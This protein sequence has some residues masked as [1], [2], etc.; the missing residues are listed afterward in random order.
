MRRAAGWFAAAGVLLALGVPA[1]GPAQAQPVPEEP[2]CTD[3]VSAW[4]TRSPAPLATMAVQDVW[5][6]GALGAGITVAV[7]HA[8]VDGRN[9]HLR[10]AMLPGRT[11]VPG[12]TDAS[13]QTTVVD[14]GTALASVVAGRRVDGSGVVGVAPEASVMSVRWYVADDSEDPGGSKQ[15]AG[16]ARLGEA[17]AWAG[18]NGADVVVVPNA[19]T[20]PD[21]AL[22]RAVASAQEAGA[23]VLAS[24]GDSTEGEPRWPAAYPG[25]LGVVG[26]SAD[27]A[28]VEEPVRGEQVAIAAPGNDVVAAESDR[29]DCLVLGPQDPPASEWAVGYLA[30]AA[31]AV[32]SGLPNASAEEVGYRLLAS[33]ERPRQSARTETTGWG[34]VRPYAALTLTLDPTRVGPPF[35]GEVAAPVP[36]GVRTIEAGR[37]V[38]DP[39]GPQ[40]RAVVWWGLLGVAALGLIVLLTRWN[41]L[42]EAAAGRPARE[43]P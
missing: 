14:E 23:L 38:V 6:E 21:P 25:V 20:A 3:D 28:A 22:E 34:E 11:F 42:A 5:D 24:A 12:D 16:V 10:G 8:G 15:A 1:T 27:G 18:Q 40:R 33:A 13:G 36:D 29:R 41:R 43:E 30:G 7:V 2:G 32:W 35:P 17:I 9:P 31:A 26:V 37:A 39:A 19:V 4:I